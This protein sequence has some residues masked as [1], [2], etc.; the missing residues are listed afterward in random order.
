[1]YTA[2]HTILCENPLQKMWDSFLYFESEPTTKQ[3]LQKA[4]ESYGFEKPNFYA[5]QNTAKFIYTIRQARQYYTAA[6]D[7]DILIRPLLLYYGMV[8]LLKAYLLMCDPEYPSNTKVL[9]HGLTSR[10]VKKLYYSFTED[11]VKVQKDGLLPH[12]HTF[13]NKDKLQEKYR[14]QELLAMVPELRPAYRRLYGHSPLLSVSL[15]RYRDFEQ[16]F[17]MFYLPESVLDDI[18]LTYD[19]FVYY[20]N[21]Y[22]EGKAYFSGSQVKAPPGIIRLE[23]HHP[24]SHHVTENG[25]G[26]ENKLFLMD[27]KGDFF[28]RTGKTENGS[29][30]LPEIINHYMV[31]YILGML[32]RYET[33]KWGEIVFSFSSEDIYIIHEFLA[34]SSRKFPN[35]VYDLLLGERHVFWSK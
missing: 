35:L 29:E 19:A 34:V 10:K 27:C 28:Y 2:V 3:F 33:E 26:F 11:E 13:L 24:D 17:T 21:R 4:Y 8:S 15:S 18:H 7:S 22:N 32:C 31:M 6:A 25:N 20:L 23:W 9:Q 16:P 30:N 1:M 5:F 14:M 12:V